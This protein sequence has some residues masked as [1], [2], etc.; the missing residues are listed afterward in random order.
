M[1]SKQRITLERHLRASYI[2]LHVLVG[3]LFWEFFDEFITM[4]ASQLFPWEGI[5]YIK[6]CWL[7]VRIF[8]RMSYNE[9]LWFSFCIIVKNSMNGHF[10]FFFFDIVIQDQ[11]A[12]PSFLPKLICLKRN[13][14]RYLINISPGSHINCFK[15]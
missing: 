8:P 6:W 5:I 3:S 7:E 15:Y 13:V 1:I 14:I 2:L 10:F 9:N 4:D 11:I 12:E